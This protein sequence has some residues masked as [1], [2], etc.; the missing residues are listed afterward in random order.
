MEARCEIGGRSFN[1]N[2]IN[3]I[4]QFHIVRRIAPMLTGM[5]SMLGSIA[6]KKG[7]ELSQEEQ[8]VQF[9]ALSEP[10]MTALSKLS[11]ADSEYVLYRLLASVEVQQKEHNIW[12]KVATADN[13]IMMQ[14]IEFPVLMQLAT[15]ALMFNIKGF[16]SLL[17][18]KGSGK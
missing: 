7:K 10:I 18:Q 12:A 13:G 17:P 6:G 3:A 16:F 11:D 15:K 5:I 4:N 8:V 9:A 14:D 1:L 2:K